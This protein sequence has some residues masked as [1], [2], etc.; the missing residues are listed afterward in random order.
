MSVEK[1]KIALEVISYLSIILGV[2]AAIYQ[3]YNITSGQLKN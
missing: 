1:I 2:P 3:Y